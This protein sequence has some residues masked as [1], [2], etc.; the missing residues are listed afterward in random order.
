LRILQVCDTYPPDRGGLGAHVRRL[1]ERLVDRGHDVMVVAAGTA[2]TEQSGDP[3][4]VHRVRPSFARLPGVYEPESPP[5]HPPWADRGFIKGVER[6]AAQLEP[7][8]VHAHGWCTYSAVRCAPAWSQRV[9]STLHDHGLAC[10]KKTLLRF[11]RECQPA[12]G[13]ACL[14]CDDQTTL[15]R[16]GLAAA[17]AITT[18]PLER[19]IRRLLAVSTYVAARAEEVGVSRGLLDVVPNFV[20]L[21]D[22]KSAGPPADVSRPYVMYGGPVT[23]HKG[24]HVLLEA[25]QQVPGV[26]LR[27]AGGDGTVCAPGV[28]DLGYQ[29]G[30][31]L[32]A[33]YRDALMLVVPSIWADPCPTVALE[34]MAW[35][36]PVVGS[37]LGGLT[38]IVDDGVTG[39]LV[40]PGEPGALREAITQLVRDPPL[41]EQMGAQSRERVALFSTDTV[42]PRL[43]TIYASTMP[44]GPDA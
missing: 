24:L 28:V 16:G 26:E 25:F 11:G 39:L 30:E 36:T 9:V 20:D 43:E 6:A 21:P 29:T 34:A 41:R 7:D 40:P 4:P 42:I 35:G 18:P 22:P 2:E 8:V 15:K 33:L 31:P 23:P 44:G 38:D 37:A 32:A 1:G 19:R 27:L 12:R 5:F 13:M 17:L 14:R 10:P 3:F